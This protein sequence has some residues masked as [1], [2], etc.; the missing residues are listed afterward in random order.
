MKATMAN[1]RFTAMPAS[2]MT[3][4]FQNGWARYCWQYSLSNKAAASGTGR[5]SPRA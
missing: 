2:R 3:E 1:S 4:R 5:G